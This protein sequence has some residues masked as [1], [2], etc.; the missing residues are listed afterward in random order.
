M[1]MSTDCVSTVMKSTALGCVVGDEHERRP[2]PPAWRRPA[3]WRSGGESTSRSALSATAPRSTRMVPSGRGSRLLLGQR[4]VELLLVDQRP[5]EELAADD[6]VGGD[7]RGIARLGDAPLDEVDVDEPLRTLDVQRA[8]APHPAEHLQDLDDA[9]RIK[10]ALHAATKSIIVADERRPAHAHLPGLGLL[11][12]LATA[13]TSPGAS[14][15][16]SRRWP[17]PTTATSPT[18]GACGRRWPPR[19]C[20]SSH[21]VEISTLFGR[22]R[23]LLARPRLPG[24]ASRRAG[25]AAG[26]RRRRTTPPWCGC[27]RA[28]AAGAAAPPTTR[29]RA[30]W[31][32]E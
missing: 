19:A 20:C 16:P 11:A 7:A 21:G 28:R 29:A 14:T 2:W 1:S 6:G 12:H 27:T 15:T 30:A 8:G 18:T 25:R 26:R 32:P 13:T 23:H 24:D 3:C 17:S 5:L 22:L 9:E 4:L 31:S 10:R